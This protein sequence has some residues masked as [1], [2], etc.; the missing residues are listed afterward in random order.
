MSSGIPS[1]RPLPHQI[2]HLVCLST[3]IEVLVSKDIDEPG[4]IPLIKKG[5]VKG[6]SRQLVR[7]AVLCNQKAVH[8]HREAWDA[9]WGC[10]FVRLIS[11]IQ[12]SPS[13]VPHFVSYRNFRHGMRSSDESGTTT[14]VL[15]F[16]GHAAASRH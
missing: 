5:L 4:L 13:H 11:C 2:I 12:S 6:Q 16:A 15:S 1:K 7:R 3:K 8:I 14:T 9:N 10:G